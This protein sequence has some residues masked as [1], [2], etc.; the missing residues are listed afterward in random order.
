MRMK[1]DHMQNGQLKPAYNVQISTNNQYIANYSLHHNTTDTNTLIEHIHEYQQSYGHTPSVITADAGYGA[2]ENYQYL[3]DKGI[4]NYVKYNQFDREQNDTI[5]SKT[6]FSADK[7][8]YNEQG[9]FYVCPMGQAMHNKGTHKSRTTTGYQ[10]IITTYEAKN[11]NNCPLNGTCHKAKGNRQISVNHALNQHKEQA[12]QNLQS[13]QGI[14]H[15]KKRCYDVEP[16][17]AN[18]KHNHQ[19]KRFMLRG[20][21]KVTTE[22]GL[23]SL[24]QNLRKKASQNIKMAA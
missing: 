2:Q 1:D 24:A 3:Q 12:R 5:Q 6:P 13:E 14:Y 11:C 4:T 21:D 17:F 8:F 20:K 18:W 15:R 23:L 10:Q 22:I 16:V 7:L 19:F 9:D